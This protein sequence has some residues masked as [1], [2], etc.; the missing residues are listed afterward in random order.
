MTIVD[1]WSDSLLQDLSEEQISEF[2][3]I[4][5]ADLKKQNITPE[6]KEIL[7]NNLDLWLYCLRVLRRTAEHQLSFSNSKTRQHNNELKIVGTGESVRSEKE[8][9]DALLEQDKRRISISKF[10]LAIERKTFYVKLLISEAE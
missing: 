2:E 5:V 8:I 9:Y 1:Y 7:N 3:S 4:V 6:H 10:L